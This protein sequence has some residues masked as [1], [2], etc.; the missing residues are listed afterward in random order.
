[1]NVLDSVTSER[2]IEKLKM[3]YSGIINQV[4]P[5]NLVP[6]NIEAPIARR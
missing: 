1:M 6:S 5:A 4:D 3:A 2:K